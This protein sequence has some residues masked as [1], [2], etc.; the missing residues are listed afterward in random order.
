VR[1]LV[2]GLSADECSICETS[3]YYEDTTRNED[4]DERR[5]R[6]E[7]EARGREHPS[8]ARTTIPETDQSKD[9]N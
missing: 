5:T 3:V 1:E 2:L 9:R 6:D 7:G 8:Q 4:E